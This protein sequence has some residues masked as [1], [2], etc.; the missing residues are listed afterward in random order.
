[1]SFAS[2][3]P[4]KFLIQ[5]LKV[6]KL[7]TSQTF[8]S[9]YLLLGLILKEMCFFFTFVSKVGRIHVVMNQF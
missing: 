6:K 3:R 5:V 8:F 4:E 1:M 9:F 2:C 7:V